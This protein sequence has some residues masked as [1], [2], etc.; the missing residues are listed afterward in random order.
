MRLLEGPNG[1]L[2]I[3]LIDPDRPIVDECNRLIAT[4]KGLFSYN[5]PEKAA[6]SCA[7]LTRPIASRDKRKHGIRLLISP[8]YLIWGMTALQGCDTVL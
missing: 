4:V 3:S 6:K 2:M 5:D 7:I 1:R 8:V